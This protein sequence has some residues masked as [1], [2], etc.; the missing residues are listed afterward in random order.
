M[1]SPWLSV[2]GIPAFGQ[3]KTDQVYLDREGLV[4]DV[5]AG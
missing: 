5:E 3:R 1:L 2:G 4:T